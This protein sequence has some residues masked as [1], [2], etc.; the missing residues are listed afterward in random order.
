M[1]L[2]LAASTHR[3]LAL[4]APPAEVARYFQGN[5]ELL[6]QLVGAE[7][8][9]RLGDRHYRVSTRGFSAFGLTVTPAFEVRFYDFSDHTRMV[10]QQ[11]QLVGG[12]GEL[13]LSASFVGEARFRGA[14]SGCELECWVDAEATVGL[15]ALARLAPEGVVRSVLQG[16][17]QATLDAVSARFVPL[18]RQDFERWCAQQV[19]PTS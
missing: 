2:E 5:E 9:E 12:S 17:M 1:P 13:E 10:S 8:V 6:A 16:L 7:F 4:D 15:P 14:E 19:S 18:I 11:C 3:H